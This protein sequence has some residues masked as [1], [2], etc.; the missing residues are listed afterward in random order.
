[1]DSSKL[2]SPSSELSHGLQV[3]IKLWQEL[4]SLDSEIGNDY[5]EEEVIRLHWCSEVFGAK[6]GE[7]P[8]RSV[9]LLGS[10]SLQRSIP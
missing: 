2:S 10:H 8:S 7:Q 9:V 6:H 3:G 4:H 5:L 1:M